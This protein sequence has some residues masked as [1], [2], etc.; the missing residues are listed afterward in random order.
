MFTF[1]WFL[2]N[3]KYLYSYHHKSYVSLFVLVFDHFFKILKKNCHVKKKKG[4]VLIL[5]CTCSIYKR[6]TLPQDFVCWIIFRGDVFYST[7]F[8]IC[9][10]F[11][12]FNHFINFQ[13]IKSMTFQCNRYK[14]K[15]KFLMNCL[16]INLPLE[17]QLFGSL[18]SLL[19][20]N[21]WESKFLI[22]VKNAQDFRLMAFS[23]VF[24]GIFHVRNRP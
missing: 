15:A 23:I 6:K 4:T 12:I 14:M 2:N 24:F 17:K 13:S 1:V 20:K 3:V 10:R 7:F 18:A 19:P 8:I 16:T 9:S 5:L 21:D 11:L 22:I